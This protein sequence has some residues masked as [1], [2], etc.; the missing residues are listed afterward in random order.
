M[1][2]KRRDNVHIGFGAGKVQDDDK[3]W[4]VRMEIHGLEVYEL[5]QALWIR[6][7]EAYEF[8]GDVSK[9]CIWNSE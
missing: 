7:Q 5:G 4:E 2:E 8:G 1:G 6:S 3:G 9:H